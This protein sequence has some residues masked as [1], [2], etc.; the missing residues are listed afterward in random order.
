M[1]SDEERRRRLKAVQFARGSVEL[2][3]FVVGP[4]ELER[5]RQFV[6][7]DLTMEEWVSDP[8]SDAGD[9]DKPGASG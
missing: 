2:S 5:A 6:A 9:P 4:R 7:G 1:I 3:G 8:H